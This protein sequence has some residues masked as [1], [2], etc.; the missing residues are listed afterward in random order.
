VLT[1]FCVDRSPVLCFL[2]VQ[3]LFAATSVGGFCAIVSSQLLLVLLSVSSV[4]FLFSFCFSV[5]VWVLRCRLYTAPCIAV[6]VLFVRLVWEALI[7][8]AVAKNKKN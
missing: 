6:L 2:R 4:T 7:I 5:F 8:Y 3:A 1:I